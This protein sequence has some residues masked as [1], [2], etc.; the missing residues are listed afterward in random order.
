MPADVSVLAGGCRVLQAA[1]FFYLLVLVSVWD[2]RFR[3][4]PD[5]IQAGIA[6]LALLDFSPE[7]LLGILGA[8]PYLAVALAVDGREGIGGGDVKLAGAIGL[9]LGLSA[10]LTASMLGLAGFVL[11]GTICGL[12]CRRHGKEG[13]AV[14]P[15]GPFLGAGAACAYWMKMGGWIV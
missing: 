2:I 5:R 3:M 14:F 12:W 4:I 9:V 13:K 10:S 8:L 15:V 11:Y 1:L 7:N 6:L